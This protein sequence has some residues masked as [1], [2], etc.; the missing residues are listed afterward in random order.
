MHSFL[1]SMLARLRSRLLLVLSFLPT[2]RAAGPRWDAKAGVWV[3]NRAAN[4]AL[5]IPS[6][7]WIFG[8][9][10]LCWRP[11]FAHEITMVGRVQ[12]Y[13][14]FF[15][16]WSCD[17]R[18]TPE[19]PGLV[20]TLVS[21]EELVAL[22]LR[23]SS[24]PESTCVGVCYRV[25]AE[26]VTE[27]L[28]NLDFREKGG[29]SRAVVDV[30]PSDGSPPFRALLYRGNSANPNFTAAPIRD[31]P[32]A[33]ATIATAHGP[34]GPNRAYLE[35]LASWLEEVGEDDEHVAA[36]MRHLPDAG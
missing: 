27:V 2:L 30:A 20:A 29:Y 25:G 33:A 21:D 17:H 8:Y 13:Q 32:G 24:S 18:G 22:G 28:A 23:D 16:Q 3:G 4:G 1:A 14:R 7:L 34:S 5:E 12:G 36:L 26:D 15:A 6:P 11:D 10:S 31:I 9:G 19:Q 35:K